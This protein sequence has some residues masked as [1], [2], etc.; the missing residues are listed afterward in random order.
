MRWWGWKTEHAFH[1][2]FRNIQKYLVLV[3]HK[4]SYWL[5]N[6]HSIKRIY[7]CKVFR[8]LQPTWAWFSGCFWITHWGTIKKNIRNCRPLREVLLLAVANWMWLCVRDQI[9]FIPGLGQSHQRWPT[10]SWSCGKR[11]VKCATPATM[12]THG[13]ELQSV[14]VIYDRCLPQ[15]FG[16][17]GK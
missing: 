15:L 6:V 3:F 9:R 1:F 14:V 13:N 5:E 7:V 8:C 2:P 10:C 12:A 4:L 16:K 11:N 17:F